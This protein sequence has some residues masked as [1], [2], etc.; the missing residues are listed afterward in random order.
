DTKTSLVAVMAVASIIAA[1]RE[2]YAYRKADKELI[3]QYR[4]M[5]RIFSGARS[6]LD[7]AHGAAEQ[8]EILRALGETALAEHAEW[9]LMHR[10]RPLEH[11]HL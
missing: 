6:A 5:C 9:T 8:R 1:V 11:A 7:R 4:F 10:E 3:K 2:A